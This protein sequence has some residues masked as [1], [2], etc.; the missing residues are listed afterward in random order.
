MSR[1]ACTPPRKSERADGVHVQPSVQHSGD[2]AAVFTVYGPW[3][4]PDMALYAFTKAILAGQPVSIFNYGKMI[5]DFTYIDDVVEGILR[6]MDRL[7]GPKDGK[8]P[9]KVL[10]IGNHRPVELLSFLELLEQKLKRP[11]NRQYMPIQPGDVPAT[12]ASVDAL[13]AETGFRPDTP[14]EVG[15]SRFVDWYLDYYGD[16]HA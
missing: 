6:L 2:R 10:N 12:F 5:R 4:R 16:A 15:I 8:A 7:P 3:G 9:H 11:A 14:V 1:T 13:F